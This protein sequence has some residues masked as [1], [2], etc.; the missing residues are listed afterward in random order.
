MDR[1]TLLERLRSREGS[2]FEV[3]DGSGGV[4]EDAYKTVA[5]FANT[6]GGWLVFG[7][8]QNDGDFE[9]CGLEDPEG[10]E[11]AFIGTCRSRQKLSRAVEI[12]LA[13]QASAASWRVRARPCCQALRFASPRFWIA[14]LR[15][16]GIACFTASISAGS[17]AS[18]S[19][20]ICTSTLWKRWKSW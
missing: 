18:T 4:P 11:I 5:A 19:A 17:V 13:S 14:V 20:A 6:A 8:R 15:S 3:K 7:V 16:F 2:D 12:G 1:E 9:I 10:V